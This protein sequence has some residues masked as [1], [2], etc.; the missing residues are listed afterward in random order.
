MTATPFSWLEATYRYTEVENRLYGPAAYSG[1]QSF[2]DK[3]FDLKFQLN[4]ESYY[5]PSTALG[6][7]DLAGTGLFSSEYLVFTKA[8]RDFDLLWDWGGDY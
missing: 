3:G 7:R 8:V 4:Q 6:I 1:N 2:K 5:F